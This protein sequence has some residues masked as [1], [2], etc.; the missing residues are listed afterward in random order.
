MARGHELPDHWVLTKNGEPSRDPNDFYDD[1]AILPMGGLMGG[2]KGYAL[3]FMTV[4][5]GRV[6]AGLGASD[7]TDS[8]DMRVG[9]SII[10][11][12]LEVASPMD[13]VHADVDHVIDFVK[14]APPM[15]GFSEVLYPGEIEANSRRDRLAAGVPMEDSTWGKVVSLIDEFDLL[16]KLGPLES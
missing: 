11:I 5:F 13:E 12:N 4:M 9:S 6:L 8:D 10:A 15:K 3:S 1:G 7:M 2:H 16:D 14:S